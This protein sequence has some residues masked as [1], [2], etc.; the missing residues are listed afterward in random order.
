MAPI[1]LYEVN[2]SYIPVA[3]VSL[4]GVAVAYTC[5]I[6][7]AHGMI[8]ARL[9]RYPYFFLFSRLMVSAWVAV[10]F[11]WICHTPAL[12]PMCRNESIKSEWMEKWINP[13][14]AG[15]GVRF[16]IALPQCLTAVSVICGIFHNGQSGVRELCSAQ[17]G[18][19][20]SSSRLRALQ[21]T[22]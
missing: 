9:I 11:V 14:I 19:E 3:I 10:G 21:L 7:S 20:S 1:P 13:D 12:D 22:L 5:E 15:P 18:C 4:L 16:G 8:T 2:R 6:A 17:I